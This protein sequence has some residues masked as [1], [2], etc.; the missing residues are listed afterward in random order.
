[1]IGA[2]WRP[3]GPFFSY[4]LAQ[5]GTVTE[6]AYANRIG[7]PNLSCYCQFYGNGLVSFTQK[8]TFLSAEI[9]APK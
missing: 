3:M 6:K 4:G 2:Q 5:C 1:M 7:F 8:T 9:I